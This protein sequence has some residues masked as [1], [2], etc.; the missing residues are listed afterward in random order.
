[1]ATRRGL[2]MLHATF[3]LWLI[4]TMSLAGILVVVI[5]GQT[6]VALVRRVA[7]RLQTFEVERRRPAS[8]R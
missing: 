8:A 3:Q 1:M 2:S 4:A 6:T 7:D 5:A